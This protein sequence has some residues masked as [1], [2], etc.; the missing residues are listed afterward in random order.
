MLEGW[1]IITAS[2]MSRIE[3]LSYKNGCSD[4]MFM[5]NA[6]KAIAQ[7]TD[8]LITESGHQKKVTLLV[9]KGNNG[10]DALVAGH[11]LLEKGYRVISHLLYPL[12]E[13]SALSQA[14]VQKFLGK[15]GKICHDS[16]FEG[17]ILDGLVGTG[18]TGKAEGILAKNIEQANRS[19]LPI[20]AIDIPSGLNGNTGEV[21]PLAIQATA[22]FFLGLPKLGFFIGQGWNHVGK[23]IYCDFG[24]PDKFIDEAKNEAWLPNE[25]ALFSLL[26]PV[27]RTRHKYEAGHVLAMAGSQAMSGAGILTSYAA[28]RSGAGIV[29]LF[30]QND[31]PLINTPWEIISEPLQNNLENLTEQMKRAHTLI[32]GPGLGKTETVK[33]QLCS[34]FSQITLPC[35]ID[36]DALYFFDAYKVPVNS[37]LTPHR[38]EM[39][40]LLREEPNFANCQTFAVEKNITLVL[41]G[42]P[43]IIFHKDTQ[44]LV[45]I[46]GDPGMA[47]AG[48]GDVLS[49]IIGGLMAQKLSG[50]HAATLGVYL[51]GKAGELAARAHTSYCMT[52]SDIIHNLPQAFLVAKNYSHLI[53]F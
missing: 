20:F 16:P 8:C 38:G 31:V 45:M 14:A 12:N 7:E 10:G 51:H 41:K 44:P 19:G 6:G 4:Q 21:D 24:L 33:H 36:A 42:A 18:F 47:T 2:E 11:Y 35:V 37:V 39:K 34:L 1:K 22:T 43:T 17:V 49:G 50:L 13:C 3:Q 52:A 29:R 30:H 5:E 26:P 9:G 53:S 25:K 15:G 27:Q 40:H 46:Q 32:V 48:S 23:L 28:L